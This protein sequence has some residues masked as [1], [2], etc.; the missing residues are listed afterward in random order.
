ML[1]GPM[2]LYAFCL[3]GTR[4]ISQCPFH[5][6]YWH[7][8]G[9]K[10]IAQVLSAPLRCLEHPSFHSLYMISVLTYS[11]TTCFTWPPEVH[12]VGK[13]HIEQGFFFW[14]VYLH[15]FL[16]ISLW[17]GPS[18]MFGNRVAFYW[19]LKTNIADKLNILIAPCLWTRYWG[20]VEKGREKNFA[21][22][23]Y[24]PSWGVHL[25]PYALPTNTH[26]K[27]TQW[28]SPAVRKE[29]LWTE[30]VGTEFNR[31]SE[32][33]EIF[34]VVAVGKSGKALERRWHWLSK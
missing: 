14:Y 2:N 10:C 28:H 24:Q 15:N 18:W 33:Q 5:L 23:S 3:E 34:F 6:P 7:K 22:G 32:E 19:Y 30:K 11:Y 17:V 16:I 12:S 27:V 13:A 4:E 1:S 20:D 26:L 25:H 31:D 29:I 21:F 9:A 8:L